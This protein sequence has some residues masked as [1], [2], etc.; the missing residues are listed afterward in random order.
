M[1]PTPIASC[2][3]FKYYVSSI[4]DYSRFVWLYRL[5]NKY[6]FLTVFTKFQLLVE[7]QFE[8]KIKVFQ[9]DGGGEFKSK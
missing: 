4:D 5:K 6:D 3:F 9:S 7:N 1:G 8:R 2:Q